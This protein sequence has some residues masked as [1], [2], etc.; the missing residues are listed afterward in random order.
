LAFAEDVVKVTGGDAFGE[1]LHQFREAIE[2][3]VLL[4]EHIHIARRGGVQ[5]PLEVRHVLVHADEEMF[6]APGG[7]WGI[8][9]IR[10]GDCVRGEWSVQVGATPP[11]CW[12]NQPS[13]ALDAGQR[14]ILEM[15]LPEFQSGRTSEP[16]TKPERQLRGWLDR[17]RDVVRGVMWGRCVLCSSPSTPDRGTLAVT[18]LSHTD[19]TSSNT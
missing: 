9:N 16:A 6:H 10:R 7:V 2:V 18:N 1:L 19:I 4:A 12:W 13:L 8:R 3:G 5:D 15:P 17:G 14:V 11:L